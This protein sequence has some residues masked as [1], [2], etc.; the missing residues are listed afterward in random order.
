MDKEYGGRQFVYDAHVERNVSPMFTAEHGLFAEAGIPPGGYRVWRD[1]IGNLFVTLYGDKN[2]KRDS[3]TVQMP[4][5]P[6][7]FTSPHA[8]GAMKH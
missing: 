3:L 4:V 6:I 2:K 5:K 7:N 8:A 1:A